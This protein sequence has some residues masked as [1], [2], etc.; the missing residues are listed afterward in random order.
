MAERRWTPRIE[1]TRRIA[2]RLLRAHRAEDGFALGALDVDRCVDGITLTFLAAELRRRLGMLWL[3]HGSD[4]VCAGHENQ[5]R[6]H[7]L[8]DPLDAL[9]GD[10]EQP[11]E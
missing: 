2:G 4:V 5:A 11:V 10:R 1:T 7:R 6:R 3:L 9:V 8:D